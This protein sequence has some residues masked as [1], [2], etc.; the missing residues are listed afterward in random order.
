MSPASAV[1]TLPHASS[2]TNLH[3]VGCTL[4]AVTKFLSPNP[5]LALG[6]GTACLQIAGWNTLISLGSE[7]PAPPPWLFVIVKG[8]HD[9]SSSS[10]NL[11]LYC[12]PD[13]SPF[14]LA[15]PWQVHSYKLLVNIG[16][17]HA[18]PQA[19]PS[20]LHS[21]HA[22]SCPLSGCNSLL[23]STFTSPALN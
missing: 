10:R 13:F 11:R 5:G 1:L 21:L 16:D 2:S 4:L 19:C 7:T 22:L 12:P 6:H 23:S 17:L 8:S 15:A 3:P 14:S 18:G 9:Q 20:P